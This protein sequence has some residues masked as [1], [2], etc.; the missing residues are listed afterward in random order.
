MQKISTKA[1]LL[2]DE[3]TFRRTMV[4]SLNQIMD[5]LAVGVVHENKVQATRAVNGVYD[6]LPVSVVAEM[7]EEEVAAAAAELNL[8]SEVI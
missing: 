1:A 6:S 7:V 2:M 8:E 4:Q 5:A 3:E